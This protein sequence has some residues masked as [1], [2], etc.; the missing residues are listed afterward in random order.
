MSAPAPAVSASDRLVDHRSFALFW[1]ARMATVI[2]FQMQAV[3]VGWQIYELTGNAFDLGLVGLVQFV[4]VVLLALVIGQTVDR[5]DRR[6]IAR[7]CQI[8]K[9]LAAAALAIGTARGWLNR[10]AILA[11]LLLSGTARAFETPT[12][13]SLVPALVPPRILTRAIAASATANQTA[14]ICGPAIG[15]FLYALG[16]TTVYV[17]CTT[18][19]VIASILVTLVRPT[20]RPRDK[21][22]V[23][24]RS[25]LAGFD[26]IYRRPVLLGIITL[27][28]FVVLVGGVTALLPI[29]ARDILITGP[30]GLG[31]LRSAPAVGALLVSVVLAHNAIERRAG[32]LLFASVA[33]FGLSTLVFALSTSLVLSLGALA[34]YGAADAISVVIRHSLV[35]TRTPS[36]MLGRVMSVNSMFTGTTSTL[37]EFRAGT[38]AALFGAVPSVVIGGIGAIVVTSVWMRAF[39]QLTRIERLGPE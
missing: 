1:C 16:P 28:L 20:P 37:G 29:Y 34:I 26:Y 18:A 8:A 4:P 13:H 25:M 31:L 19:F 6:T 27:D 21:T 38:M 10:D 35:Q 7:T 11:I 36:E 32:R 5:F 39:P 12:M 24:L 33:V 14:V 22:P 3:A 15:G 9:G 30:W 17:T 23:T 2:A